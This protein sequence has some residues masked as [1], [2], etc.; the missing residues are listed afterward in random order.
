MNLPE[1][2]K[3][4][5]E[6]VRAAL[7]PEGN[8]IPEETVAAEK[9]KYEVKK[10]PAETITNSWLISEIFPPAKAGTARE[11]IRKKPKLQECEHPDETR[12]TLTDWATAQLRPPKKPTTPAIHKISTGELVER[13]IF[14]F[15]LPH[16]GNT[17]WF[18]DFRIGDHIR[19]EKSPPP[20]QT[21]AVYQQ[22]NA[23]VKCCSAPDM[24]SYLRESGFRLIDTH[25]KIVG[26]KERIYFTFALNNEQGQ[27]PVDAKAEE[28]F[29][30]L[31]QV[32]F[33]AI[34][35]WTNHS[36]KFLSFK[37]PL[38]GNVPTNNLV[39]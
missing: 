18:D 11:P 20:K 4:K 19:L 17:N 23:S 30:N 25:Y 14:C 5:L 38:L 27:H 36:G 8:D 39:L 31:G 37:G 35:I 3:S 7:L 34:D 26:I 1:D 12:Q 29:T 9:K 15:V 13:F 32:T 33:T 24:A 21:K 2:V 16:D 10:A 28:I 6:A 22:P